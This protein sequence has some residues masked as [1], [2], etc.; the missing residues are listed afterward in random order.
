MDADDFYMV[1]PCSDSWEHGS[2]MLFRMDP[3]ALSFEFEKQ[4]TPSGRGFPRTF[5][6]KRKCVPVRIPSLDY[7]VT[8]L[9]TRH[10]SIWSEMIALDNLVQV[11]DRKFQRKLLCVC[12][13]VKH[14]PKHFSKI[15][16]PIPSTLLCYACE[17]SMYTMRSKGRRARAEW[18]M[19]AHW[20]WKNV[21]QTKFVSATLHRLCQ[22]RF[23]SGRQHCR[24]HA[25]EG[26]RQVELVQLQM[27]CHVRSATLH[28]ASDT[29]SIESQ[30]HCHVRI[31]LL[32]HL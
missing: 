24:S 3:H 10:V 16:R 1:G 12:F 9:T 23:S 8:M 13:D 7:A 29:V 2:R 4:H 11:W 28:Q 20:A 30:R 19:L 15:L 27:L 31:C 32:Q 18:E 14:A 5:S 17:F 21:Y 6:T 25:S 26:V 22:V